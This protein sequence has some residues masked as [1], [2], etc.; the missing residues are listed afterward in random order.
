MYDVCVKI[1]ISVKLTDNL[2]IF[3]GNVKL[4][5]VSMFLIIFL[6]TASIGQFFQSLDKL[7]LSGL[8]SL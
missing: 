8:M 2:R 5:Q 7:T 3:T 4:V 6:I 1:Y